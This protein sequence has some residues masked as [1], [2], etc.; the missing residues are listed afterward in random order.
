MKKKIVNLTSQILIIISLIFVGLKLKGFNID[1]KVYQNH[2]NI[3]MI[4]ISIMMLMFT[5]IFLSIGWT[6]ILRQ[7]SGENIKYIHTMPIYIQTNLSKYVPGNIMQFA[8][9]NLLGTQYGIV[10]KILTLSTIC[11]LSILSFIGIFIILITNQVGSIFK[12][13]PPKYVTAIVII[14]LTVVILAMLLVSVKKIKL[15]KI[16]VKKA[17]LIFRS[18]VVNY[19]V[20]LIFMGVSFV[21][22][23]LTV[24]E[25]NITVV[26]LITWIGIFIVAWFIGFITPG[27][28]GGIGIREVILI[29]YMNEVVPSQYILEAVLI[30]RVISVIADLLLYICWAIFNWIRRYKKR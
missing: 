27:A 14:L 7:I 1:F 16:E 5:I 25:H 18:S 28:P 12:F 6:Q 15:P 19:L 8:G 11:E 3:E 4:I 23:M 24:Y 21:I 30:H 2:K 10:Q 17:L 29:T 9:R 13:L 26:D 20:A 22:V